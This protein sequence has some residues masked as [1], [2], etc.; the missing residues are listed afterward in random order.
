MLTFTSHVVKG[1]DFKIG[2]IHNSPGPQFKSNMTLPE[3]RPSKKNAWRPQYTGLLSYWELILL[4]EHHLI[5]SSSPFLP[6]FI[7]LKWCRISS[8]NSSI[9]VFFEFVTVFCWTCQSSKV[10]KHSTVIS[11]KFLLTVNLDAFPARPSMSGYAPF[12]VVCHRMA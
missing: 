9:Y 4:M 11:W 8:V 10:K 1:G 2:G 5:G 7:H 12:A 6:A 3:K